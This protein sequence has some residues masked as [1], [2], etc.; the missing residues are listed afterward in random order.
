[1]WWL[2]KWAFSYV[3]GLHLFVATITIV[4]AIIIICL[5][6]LLEYFHKV[7]YFSTWSPQALL[8]AVST[9]WTEIFLNSLTQ[10]PP[11]FWG[12]GGRGRLCMCRDLC[13]FFQQALYNSFLHH[14]LLVHSLKF[15]PRWVTRL[16]LSPYRACAQA[17][18]LLW[19]YKFKEYYKCIPSFLQ[20]SCSP[21]LRIVGRPFLSPRWSHCF[22]QLWFWTVVSDCFWK[23]TGK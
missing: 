4:I 16:F 8:S 7:C 13:S 9:N 21:I 22:R 1:M 10:K 2:W 20:T 14:S 18:M 19:S 6:T 3:H 17:S 12:E 5:E 11:V 15:G 23:V